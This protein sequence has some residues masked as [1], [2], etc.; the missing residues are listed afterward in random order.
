LIPSLPSPPF[1]WE[2]AHKEVL[3]ILK[4]IPISIRSAIGKEVVEGQGDVL[5]MKNS[6]LGL[7][8]PNNPSSSRIAAIAHLSHMLVVN[9]YHGDIVIDPV[10]MNWV[11]RNIVA[12]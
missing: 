3:D 4:S 6:A 1:L 5:V 7:L 2:Y 9:R 11:H 12:P 10:V 8:D